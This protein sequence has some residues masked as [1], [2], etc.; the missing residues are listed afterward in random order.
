MPTLQYQVPRAIQEGLRD[1]LGLQV[2]VEHPGD[3]PEQQVQP[4]RRE[5]QEMQ[6]PRVLWGL[7]VISVRPAR[8]GSPELQ[9]LGDLQGLVDLWAQR[10]CKDSVAIRGLPEGQGPVVFLVLKERLDQQ[11]SK[12]LPGWQDLPARHQQLPGPQAPAEV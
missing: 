9:V 11:V 5:I 8:Q 6:E 7:P 10:V 1:L 3:L 4:G 12:G 2:R